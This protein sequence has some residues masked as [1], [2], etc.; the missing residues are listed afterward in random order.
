ML[1]PDELAR[2]QAV[3][4]S[5]L[6]EVATITRPGTGQTTDGFPSGPTVIEAAAPCRVEPASSRGGQEGFT[7]AGVTSSAAWNIVLGHDCAEVK[8][9]DIIVVDG[10]GTFEVESSTSL[11][12]V[13][14]DTIARCTKRDS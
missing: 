4:A 2:I 5:W 14:T 11:R 8:A 9:Q 6:N 13:Q 12:G 7:G 1:R 3:N 10:V